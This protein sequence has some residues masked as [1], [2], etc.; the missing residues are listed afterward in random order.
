MNGALEHDDMSTYDRQKEQIT[1]AA[2]TGCEPIRMA[3]VREMCAGGPLN[4]VLAFLR[5]GKEV[6]NW[7]ERRCARRVPFIDSACLGESRK[8]GMMKGAADSADEYDYTISLAERGAGGT[9]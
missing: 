4:R 5:E 8:A 7:R 9:D 6:E 3:A 1:A 2:N